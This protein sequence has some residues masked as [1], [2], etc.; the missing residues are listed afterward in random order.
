MPPIAA[1]VAMEAVT[2]VIT[3]FRAVVHE[4]IVGAVFFKVIAEAI[5]KPVS[6]G[7]DAIA[8]HHVVRVAAVLTLCTITVVKP[9]LLAIQVVTLVR[10]VAGAIA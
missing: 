7:A 5:T 3:E 9:I 8:V 2:T 6:R 4:R 10:L 1:A